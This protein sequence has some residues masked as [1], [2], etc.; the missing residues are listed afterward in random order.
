MKIRIIALALLAGC[1]APAAWAVRDAGNLGLSNDIRISLVEKAESLSLSFD[2][3]STAATT[4]KKTLIWKRNYPETCEIRAANGG[5]YLNDV[6]LQNNEFVI[7][8]AEG[9]RARVKGHTWEGKL[10]VRKDLRGRF[11]LLNAIPV[12]EYIEGVVENEVP[13]TWPLDALKAQAIASRTF[14][15][16]RML[17]AA[18]KPYD[19]RPNFQSYNVPRRRNPNV[20]KAVKETEGVVMIYKG[21]VFPAFYHSMCGGVTDY[22]GNNWPYPFKFPDNVKYCKFCSENTDQVSW[23]VTYEASGIERKLKK[24][25]YR[26]EEIIDI[27]P[28][29]VSNVSERITEFRIENKLGEVFIRTNELRRVLGFDRLKSN[30]FQVR[31]RGNRYIFI[32]LGRGHGAGMC[33]KG[34]EKM[35]VQ[36]DTFEMILRYYY[37]GIEF[38]RIQW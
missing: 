13:P 23:S 28:Y 3:P 15:V 6:F 26:V 7:V 16:F 21:R 34:C 29:K 31:K 30:Y 2:G 9:T 10:I 32:G 22:A 27:R 36:G 8:M 18:D 17:V 5:M 24:N 4:D 33:Q 1:L 20:L 25:G 12:E 11:F 35:A 19:M 38:R 14:S 37:P